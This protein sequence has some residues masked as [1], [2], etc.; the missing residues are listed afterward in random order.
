MKI[1]KIYFRIFLKDSVPITNNPIIL[2]W[3]V[4]CQL[5]SFKN[6]H[7]NLSK[8]LI[9]ELC[10]VFGTSSKTLSIKHFSK[11]WILKFNNLEFYIFTSKGKGTKIE[12]TDTSY[13]D[14]N[15]GS[16]QEE[17][18]NFLDTLHKNLNNYV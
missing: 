17:I 4:D 5:K 9:N 10:K 6:K 12:I 18:L 3:L 15:S 1:T 11:V 16:H 7:S 14:I 8:N 13:E 2:Q